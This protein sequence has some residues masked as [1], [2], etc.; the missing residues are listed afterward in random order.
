MTTLDLSLFQQPQEIPFGDTDMISS[1][2]TAMAKQSDHPNFGQL[3]LFV[4]EAILEVVCV[5]LPGYILARQG[6]LDAEKQ[7]F[8]S[9]LNTQ[10][11][12]P[13]LIFTK[14]A[15]QLNGDKL[16]ELAVIPF[17]FLGMTAFSYLGAF[18]ISKLFGFKKRA[19]NYVIAM[20]VFGNSNSLPLSLV[21]SLS[22]TISGLHWDKIPGDN[23][24]EVA[25]RGIL[26]LMIFQQLGQLLR[27]SWGYNVLLA[28]ADQYPEDE[29]YNNSQAEQGQYRDESSDGSDDGRSLLGHASAPNDRSQTLVS[30]SGSRTSVNG[31]NYASSSTLSEASS[32]SN[33]NYKPNQ[34]VY[35]TPTNGNIVGRGPGNLAGHGSRQDSAGHIT[36]FPKPGDGHLIG[37]DDAAKG[38][39]RWV[40]RCQQGV[41]GFWNPIQSKASTVSKRL[42][43]ALP[44]PVQKTLT[45]TY[46]YTIKFGKGCWEFM[47]PPLWAM[48]LAVIVAS[49]PPLKSLFYTDGS[50]IKNS[51]SNAI[52]SSGNVAVPLILVVLGS[53]LAKNTLPDEGPKTKEIQKEERNILVAAILSRM[54]VPVI[55]MGPIYAV[56]AKFVP[57]SILDDPIFSVVLYLLLGAPSAL[58]LSQICQINNVY[59]V[60]MSKL[61]F[62]SYVVLILPST[63]ILVVVALEVVKWAQN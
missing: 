37:L 51:V 52:R 54:V 48:L 8:I 41:R 60:V 63:L 2:I 44:G 32:S 61:L 29:G 21:S 20:A 31:P 38:W 55:I 15:S 59:E 10:I 14:L 19:T 40:Q 18:V 45:T 34:Y 1:P 56:A 24:N 42:F 58:Q 47:N 13:C 9:N 12:T 16:V 4:F 25:A 39:K 5:S 50:F 22:Q 53:N 3:L 23:D 33:D 30:E 6:M 43:N 49:V 27:W 57:V 7:K 11:F 35:P 17:L 36:S 26:Y 46:R 28:P 62:Y